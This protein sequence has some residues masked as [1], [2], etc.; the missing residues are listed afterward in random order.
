MGSLGPLMSPRRK[1]I[2]SSAKRN[3]ET[4]IQEAEVEPVSPVA[5]SLDFSGPRPPPPPPMVPEKNAVYELT[6]A[7]ED[8]C[9]TCLEDYTDSN[10]K[11]DTKCGHTFH[12]SCILEWYERNPHCP[13]CAE[14]MDLNE[15]GLLS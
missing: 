13:I 4:R 12:L 6:T 1:A 10:P 15:S 8:N 5:I 2:K 11:I 9:P 7:E 14:R 3:E